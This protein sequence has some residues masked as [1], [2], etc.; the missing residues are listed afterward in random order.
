M[1]KKNLPLIDELINRKFSGGSDESTESYNLTEINTFL[2][3]WKAD[4]I[5]IL[6][7]VEVERRESAAALENMN[8]EINRISQERENLNVELTNARARIDTLQD[9]LAEIEESIE[10]S[11]NIGS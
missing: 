7:T 4:V 2:N 11:E 3:E 8:V 10:R 1:P 9:R 6:K 5:G